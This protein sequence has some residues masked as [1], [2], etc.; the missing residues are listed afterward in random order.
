MIYL[1]LSAVSI[2]L[3]FLF[4]RLFGR[5]LVPE[6]VL[7]FAIGVSWEVV[8]GPLWAYNPAML[9]IFYV[10][11]QEIPLEVLLLWSATLSSFSLVIGVIR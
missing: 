1:I 10:E 4:G 6:I 5:N 3:V 9:T 2:P 8:T 11:G 7:G